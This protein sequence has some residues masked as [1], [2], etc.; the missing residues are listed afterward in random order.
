MSHAWT[1]RR[2]L[3]AVAKGREAEVARPTLML[4]VC[5]V[6]LR[7]KMVALALDLLGGTAALEPDQTL[8]KNTPDNDREWIA[9]SLR[10]LA[11]SIG[12]GTGNIQLNVIGER[13]YGLPRD[14]RRQ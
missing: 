3:S 7:E 1:V 2:R 5:G 13:G 9:A 10:A 12:G 4:K 11:Y 14:L 8:Y 6:T